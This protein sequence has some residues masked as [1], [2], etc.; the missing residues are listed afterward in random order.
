MGWGERELREETA[1]MR[2][3]AKALVG[4]AHRAEDLA[5]DAWVAA[6]EGGR[7]PAS[8]RG[9][10]ATVLSR[11]AST[12]RR[13]R[14]RRTDRERRAARPERGPGADEAVA[15]VELQ[16]R[17]AREVF[18]LEEPF[19]QAIALRYFQGWPPRRIA[20]ELGL[21]VR[22]V[23]S[24]L[25]RGL[26]RLRER[27]D[28]AHEGRREEWLGGVAALA[29][30]GEGLKLAPIGA[31]VAGVAVAAWVG[32]GP[33]RAGPAA[34]P[35]RAAEAGLAAVA[36]ASRSEE[37]V[38]AWAG[39][40]GAG[41]VAL[42]SVR[43]S[44]AATPLAAAEQVARVRLLR[45]GDLEPLAGV[46]VEQGAG[47]WT[48]DGDGVVVVPWPE[49]QVFRVQQTP[50]TP[51]FDVQVDS[52]GDHQRLVPQR[53]GTLRGTVVDLEGNA[54]PLAE[55][56]LFRDPRKAGTPWQLPA[57]V[58]R[59]DAAGRF[60]FTNLADF[61]GGA[62]HLYRVLA[63]TPDLFSSLEVEGRVGGEHVAE[64][65]IVLEPAAPL[66]GHVAAWDAEHLRHARVTAYPRN[67]EGFERARDLFRELGRGRNLWGELDRF[68]SLSFA[69]ERDGR[70]RL[71]LPATTRHVQVDHRDYPQ[72]RAYV[73]PGE[74]VEAWL[75]EGSL[76]RGRVLGPN[77]APVEDAVV[78]IMAHEDRPATGTD[79]EG[80]FEFEALTPLD[81]LV[82]VVLVEGLA[83][84][85]TSVDLR[86]GLNEVAVRLEPE[87]RVEGRL[88]DAGGEPVPRVQLQ[89]VGDRLVESSWFPRH[90]GAT[91]QDLLSWLPG[92]SNGLVPSSRAWTDG[93]GRFEF[94]GLH[95]GRFHVE[96]HHHSQ[97][98]WARVPADGGPFTVVL[99][100][101]PGAASVRCVLDPW[102]E[103][104]ELSS[105]TLRPYVEGEDQPALWR[106]SV[107]AEPVDRGFEARGL[108][109]GRWQVM[110]TAA[111]GVHSS[112]VLEL[113]PGLHVL[114]VP[115]APHGH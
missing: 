96:T 82:L 91:W 105:V 93:E 75:G 22:A 69:T 50:S 94:G 47:A 87:F 15:R 4:D 56:R 65:V 109:P 86:A 79:A 30:G 62:T 21:D 46:I 32:L 58:A 114:E 5:Q 16:E 99:G 57:L 39:S 80:V 64:T 23:E 84:S 27:L 78:R 98:T 76:L 17:L 13:A 40:E 3:L 97:R 14:G 25:R 67:L 85:V 103:R 100:E 51:Y 73:E 8:R 90:R 37:L 18:A 38:Q 7:E 10:F 68:P 66:E 102:P 29:L 70:F 77:G 88:V 106:G 49:A 33:L 12:G 61:N 107:S 113:G 45:A 110:A 59:A 52:P 9:W 24:R 81:G 104:P 1:W 41:E 36:A 43:R 108:T 72:W 42:E 60:E 71:P 63:S 112:E 53:G 35:E 26:A 74:F 83:G 92:W 54:V 28:A 31:A 20:R 101:T 115:L 34:G 11:R 48:A 44:A 111:E 55:V 95:P 19:R 6:L 2:R 89:I